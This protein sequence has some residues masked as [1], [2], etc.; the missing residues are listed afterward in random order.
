MMAFYVCR[1]LIVHAET[2]A[3]RSRMRTLQCPACRSLLRH[4]AGSEGRPWICPR[5]GVEVQI[6][7]DPVNP[8]SPLR[9]GA[10]ES[11]AE[12]PTEPAGGPFRYPDRTWR[13]FRFPSVRRFLLVLAAW[14]LPC[15]A[16]L[17]LTIRLT[18]PGSTPRMILTAILWNALAVVGMSGM[19]VPLDRLEK[20]LSKRR[21]AARGRTFYYLETGLV[22]FGSLILL[23]SFVLWMIV[24]W[25][26][27]EIPS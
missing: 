24:L 25:R 19:S 23:V 3:E 9:Q 10:N 17:F 27:I 1:R 12:K 7:P 15:V 16:G 8:P 5:C 4:P 22:L 18:P 14:G 11:P 6:D 21:R 13:V 20:E 2:E 26:L